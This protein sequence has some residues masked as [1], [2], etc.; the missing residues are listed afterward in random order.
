MDCVDCHNRPTHIYQLPDQAVDEAILKGRISRTLP[1]IRKQAVRALRSE[2]GSREEA[3]A[4]IEQSLTEFY[5][6]NG[7]VLT[8]QQNAA[9]EQAVEA[10]TDICSSRGDDWGELQQTMREQGRF[11]V[12]TYH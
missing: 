7:T 2:F 1:F 3:A 8:A 6:E 5:R 12:E 4:G 10:L 11:H 9:L